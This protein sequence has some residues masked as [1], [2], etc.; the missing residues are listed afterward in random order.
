MKWTI[1]GSIP[2]MTR[3]FLFETP[4]LNYEPIQSPI[5]WVPGVNRPGCE[6]DHS[7]PS[8]GEV[9]NGWSL[10]LYASC[11]LSCC[12]QRQF[13]LLLL[14]YL[15]LNYSLLLFKIFVTYILRDSCRHICNYVWTINI[16]TSYP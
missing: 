11:M 15:L 13:Y 14:C 8:S 5:Q 2:V 3:D 6:S 10:Y 9:K 7:P 12:G 4:R 16:P 1:R